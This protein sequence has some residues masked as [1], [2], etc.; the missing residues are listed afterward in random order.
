VLVC[1]PVLWSCFDD[2]VLWSCFTGV[3]S[4]SCICMH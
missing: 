3:V 1:P 4:Y 2:V